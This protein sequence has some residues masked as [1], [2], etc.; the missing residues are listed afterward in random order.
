MID[1]LSNFKT[2]QELYPY[3]KEIYPHGTA[4]YYITYDIVDG[5]TELI[6]SGKC[7]INGSVT[8]VLFEPCEL[9][10]GC[11]FIQF[12]LIYG[13]TR[14]YEWLRDN[15]AS[16]DKCMRYAIAGGKGCGEASA[17]ESPD[18]QATVERGQKRL[19]GSIRAGVGKAGRIRHLAGEPL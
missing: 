1:L 8:S 10:Q 7:D 3:A 4:G 11:R 14:C 15:G 9:A 16:Q 13:S 6:G 5:L 18:V 2:V 12:A 17:A 19:V